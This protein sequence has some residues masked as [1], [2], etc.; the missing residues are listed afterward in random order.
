MDNEDFDIE[1]ETNDSGSDKTGMDR[2]MELINENKK[3]IIIV[4][5]VILLL[6]IMSAVTKSGDSKNIKLSEETKTITTAS[7]VQLQLLVD[8]N[9]TN[10]GVTWSS[11]D[12]KVAVV[13]QK[14]AVRGISEGKATITATYE[15][16]KYTC[17]ITVSKG[18]AGIAIEKVT[19]NEGTLVMTVGSTYTPVV[20]IVPGEAQVR[21]K[22]YS[23]SDRNVATVDITSGEVTANALGTATIRV[24]V[25]DAEKMGALKVWVINDEIT[26]GLYKLPTSIKLAENEIT[27]TEGERKT[28]SFTQEPEGSTIDYV[29]WISNDPTTAIVEN[30]ELVALK[31]GDTDI[32]LSSF[33]MRDTLKVHVKSASVEVTTIE[34]TSEMTISM[35]VGD[36]RKVTAKVMPENATNKEI[37]FE[38]SSPAIAAVDSVGNVTGVSAGTATITVK[39]ASKPNLYATVTVNVQG[40][41]APV[42]P[43]PPSG[44]GDP[45]GG[46]TTTTV[47]TAKLTSNNDAVESSVSAL[48]GKTMTSTKLT[49]S[50]TGNVDKVL[51]CY[52]EYNKQ[53]DCSTYSVYNG[54]F[55]FKTPGTFV[56]KVTPYYNNNAGSVL[57][58]YVKISGSGTGTGKCEAGRYL[59]G[60]SCI[61]CRAGTYCKDDKKYNCPA[62]TGSNDYA[63]AS[64]DCKT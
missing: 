60:S 62:G 30:N 61:P 47:G 8:G 48:S 37:L 16:E 27:L 45:S 2:V 23:S 54:P 53:T 22:I 20:E 56:F 12:E 15:N 14:G 64:T 26:P 32:T 43:N 3:L 35:N 9:E 17:E 31:P 55:E 19:F 42:D 59:S 18:E 52:Y 13:D 11:S 10:T 58:R 63:T 5:V 49:I 44:G 29:K 57:I 25:N 1:E 39:S 34:L 51:Y 40:S 6:I 7:G 28:L 24:A 50:T 21:N 36:S 4:G 38:S 41:T 33:G 46:G